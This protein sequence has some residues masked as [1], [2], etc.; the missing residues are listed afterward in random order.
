MNRPRDRLFFLGLIPRHWTVVAIAI[1]GGG[2]RGGGLAPLPSLTGGDS[3]QPPPRPRFALLPRPLGRGQCVVIPGGKPCPRVT[4]EKG[5]RSLSP[6]TGPWWLSPPGEGTGEGGGLPSL[7]GIL[8][9]P[10]LYLTPLRQACAPLILAGAVHGDTG[11]SP[12]LR[13]HRADRWRFPTEPDFRVSGRPGPQ[14]V[15]ISRPPKCMGIPEG[16]VA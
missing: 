14:R 10:F 1:G 12:G 13:P 4:L 2:S 7:H 15:N 5:S 6:Y 8:A 16:S 9:I 3:L 11:C